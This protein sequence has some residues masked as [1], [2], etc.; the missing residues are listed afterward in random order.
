MKRISTRFALL[1]AAA[2]VLPLLAYGVV[3]IV[4]LR[5][6]AQRAVILGNQNVARQVAE[7]IELYVTG[8]VNILRAVAADLQQTGLERWQKDRILKNFVLQF[9]EFREL[10]L[11]DEAGRPTVSSR[12]GTPTVSV[13]GSEGINVD[14]ALISG[15]TLDNDL[16]PTAIVAIR[17]DDLDGGGWLVGRLS[18]EALWRMVDRIRVGDAGYALVVT[19][20]GQLLAHGDPD[21]KTRVARGDSRA[22]SANKPSR[23]VP[24]ACAAAAQLF[25]LTHARRVAETAQAA[26]GSACRPAQRAQDRR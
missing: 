6:G 8:S 14:G 5:T 20:E 11:L 13:P 17:L 10:T 22:R 2:A 4:S 26:R 9:T 23:P 1:M 19:R 16:L 3:S 18:L 12:L 15:F 21:A 7:Q 24:C 25:L